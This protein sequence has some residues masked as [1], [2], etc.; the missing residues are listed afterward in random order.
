MAITE[1]KRIWGQRSEIACFVSLGTGVTPALRIDGILHN[2]TQVMKDIVE[3]CSRVSNEVKINLQEQG[4]G[5]C[6]YRFCVESLGGIGWE[7]WRRKDDVVGQTKAFMESMSHEVLA[8]TKSLTQPHHLRIAIFRKLPLPPPPLCFGREKEISA[9]KNAALAGQHVAIVGGAGNGK[10][11]VALATLHTEEIKS[12]FTQQL[13]DRL[14]ERRFW[15]RCD[16]FNTFSSL[17]NHLCHSIFCLVPLPGTTELDMVTG[18][19]QSQKCLLV[20]DNLET[21][22]G[23]DPTNF[24]PFLQ[25]LL[26]NNKAR[27]VLVVAHRG[28]RAERIDLQGAQFTAVTICGLEQDIACKL[29]RHH[30]QNHR[31][32]PDL[33]TTINEINSCLDHH[34]LSIRLFALRARHDRDRSL[35]QLRELWEAM[36]TDILWKD[37]R[38]GT[39]ALASSISFSLRSPVVTASPQALSALAILS[40]T[41]E[42]LV[43]D[44]LE[45]IL[46][47]EDSYK[48]VDS[49]LAIG[50]AE[51]IGGVVTGR[52]RLR[53]LAPIR[54][55]LNSL[56]SL[57]RPPFLESVLLSLEPLVAHQIQTAK[58]M[59]EQ[60]EVRERHAAF[61]CFQEEYPNLEHLLM[62]TMSQPPLQ[63]QVFAFLKDAAHFLYSHLFPS[64]RLA[65]A[66]VD[67]SRT[68]VEE[69]T[70][71]ATFLFYLAATKHVKGNTLDAIQHYLEAKEIFL[72]QGRRKNVAACLEGVANLYL[73]SGRHD[74]ALQAFREA[75]EINIEEGCRKG[76]A[77]C[78]ARMGTI[79]SLRGR[80][81]SALKLFQEAMEIHL[82][83]GDRGGVGNI[84]HDIGGVECLCGR[85][86]SALQAFQESKKIAEEERN[87]GSVAACLKSIGDVEYRYWR[88]DSA[89]KAFQEAKEI[90]VQMNM[91]LVLA[92]C[93]E[94]IG[95][96]DLRCKR[97]D[98]A[99][100][101]FHKA[102]ELNLEFGYASGVAGC[103]NN[104][105]SVDSDCGRLD[106]ALKAFQ[107]AKEIHLRLGD[108]LGVAAS[109]NNIGVVD[110]RCSRSDSA[111]R[112][113]KEA[114]EICLEVNHRL[115]LADCNTRIGQALS[116][117]GRYDSALQ[118]FQEAKEIYLAV[119]HRLKLANCTRCIGEVHLRSGR[120]DS[121][122]EAFQESKEIYLEL[123]CGFGVKECL[124][125]IAAVHIE[126]GRD[127]SA[128]KLVDEPAPKGRLGQLR[129][130]NQIG[131]GEGERRGE[132]DQQSRPT[133]L[134]NAQS[135]TQ[136]ELPILPPS[137]RIVS[138]E[139][140]A[141]KI[142][143][144]PHL[145]HPD[146]SAAISAHLSKVAT[147]L[148][149][150]STAT[151]PPTLTLHLTSPILTFHPCNI[152]H[153]E[154]R[155]QLESLLLELD[156]IESE[157]DENVR[158]ERKRMVREAEELLEKLERGVKEEWEMR[159]RKIE[160]AVS[161][162]DAEPTPSLRH[163][164]ITPS[165]D[166]SVQRKAR[167]LISSFLPKFRRTRHSK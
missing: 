47:V 161:A 137:Q 43:H 120:Y 154:L 37:E 131:S 71:V 134:A 93:L 82:E 81:D 90:F 104:I 61:M 94:S 56:V 26:F 103:L 69:S 86:N 142:Q 35:K 110:L 38:D 106:S 58:Q 1:S 4:L 11:T 109:L 128:W 24:Q 96:V 78:L 132:T 101:G 157:G 121:S 99:L 130:P 27:S 150:L 105:G 76:V 97:Y 16:A 18:Y 152:P 75:K 53:I 84:L 49:I 118:A 151:L 48:A 39:P 111:L 133:C 54:E 164:K 162:S 51:R 165:K 155:Q 159:C 68:L 100:E 42:G 55:H 153:R 45:A 125:L 83:E 9:I 147:K 127:D 63:R 146:P 41:P 163:S 114:K 44:D 66:V 91:P 119:D 108:R 139:P 57:S 117:C 92:A 32:S 6:F 65:S 136:D 3:D 25:S 95:R 22:A 73:I 2:L 33:E 80:H 138:K 123:D 88:T 29:F 70:V 160:A 145:L 141:H 126:C 167:N 60:F 135:S 85:P 102:K 156:G 89:L 98:S 107:E 77:G 5:F 143:S 21:P 34:P 116:Q 67:L 52:R 72:E 14:E 129:F 8:L 30:F 50:L 122:L 74:S 124:E 40:W 46:S 31:D 158:R 64:V 28:D 144:P 79:D 15:V 10:S 166:P 20:L 149:T 7:D 148:A 140:S 62:T 12:A 13:E 23:S 17:W 87:P 115:A 59:I 19:F 112:A 113:F 36:K